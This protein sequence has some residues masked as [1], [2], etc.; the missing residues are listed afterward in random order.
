MLSLDTV[1][2]L[3]FA[4]HGTFLIQH[5]LLLLMPTRIR[6]G[7]ITSLSGVDLSLARF[8]T[9]FATCFLTDAEAGFLLI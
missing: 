6:H 4:L 7:S 2:C 9:G 8:C 1:V 5:Y 3:L